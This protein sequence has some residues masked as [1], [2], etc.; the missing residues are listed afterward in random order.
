RCQ[1]RASVTLVPQQESSMVAVRVGVVSLA[2]AL[3]A[4]GTT[5]AQYSAAVLADNPV[6]YYSLNEEG[7]GLT[8]FSTNSS[9]TPGLDAAIQNIGNF[10]DVGPNNIGQVGPRP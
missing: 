10:G 6:V 7:D 4:A 8:F 2:A 9:T 1:R 3:G 5:H